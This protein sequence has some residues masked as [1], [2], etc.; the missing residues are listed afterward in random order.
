MRAPAARSVS[1]PEKNAAVA[2]S[3]RWAFPPALQPTPGEV[4]FDLKSAL[5]SVVALRAEIPD[6][7]FTASILGTDRTGNGVVIRDDG[8]VLTIGYLITE[9]ASVWLTANDGYGR[10]RTSARLRFCDGLRARAAARPP[11]IAG[12]RARHVRRPWRRTT[13]SMSS[14]T[15]DGRTR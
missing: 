3:A 4:G 1:V 12:A 11:R 15:A 7:A 8:L 5:D 2:E 10:C 6:D 13:T 14:G 9:A